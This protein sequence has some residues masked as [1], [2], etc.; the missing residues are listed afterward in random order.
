VAREIVAATEPVR[1]LGR[2]VQQ[3]LADSAG[4]LT[5]VCLGG[6]ETVEALGPA[7]RTA[8]ET[9]LAP[10]VT[11]RAAAIFLARHSDPVAAFRAMW[12]AGAPAWAP[13]AETTKVFAPPALGDAARQAFGADV[14]FTSTPDEVA[15]VRSARTPLSALPHCGAAAKAAYQRRKAAGDSPHSRVDMIFSVD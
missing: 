15:V 10:H 3:H 6:E 9:L 5:R 14:S 11:D 4:G 1:E 7:L 2:R 8:A 12:D 13:D